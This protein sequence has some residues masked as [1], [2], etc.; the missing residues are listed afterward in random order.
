MD[1]EQ[2]EGGAP[3]KETVEVVDIRNIFQKL[4]D[5]T[6][7]TKP[8]EL[9]KWMDSLPK[10]ERQK[11]YDT[12]SSLRKAAEPRNVLNIGMDEKAK[13][14]QVEE[15]TETPFFGDLASK[16]ESFRKQREEADA[17]QKQSD[18]TAA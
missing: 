14:T 13:T 15:I 6:A 2:P 17:L 11:L 10:D 3:A 8:E 7:G 18:Q 4:V 9:S 16:A 1:Q 5:A 12:L